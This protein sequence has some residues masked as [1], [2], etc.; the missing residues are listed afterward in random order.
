MLSNILKLVLILCPLFLQAMTLEEKVGQ[1]LI[2]HFNGTEANEDARRLIQ[3]GHVGGIIY[4]R[5]SNGLTSPEQV[6]KLSEGLQA[7]S[8]TPLWICTDQE[9][10]PVSRLQDGFKPFVGNK[11]LVENYSVKEVADVVQEGAKQL[12]AVG[13]NMNL[14]PVVDISTYPSTSYIVRRTFGNNPEVVADYA[15]QA[16]LGY[17]RE[18]I[19]AVIKHFP[20]YGEVSIDPHAALPILSKDLAGLKKW[21]LVPYERLKHNADAVM[22][23]HISVPAVDPKHCAT[24]SEIFLHKILREQIDYRGLVI[25]DSLMMQGL[26]AECPN[27]EE[28]AIQAVNAGC[29][30]LILGGKQLLDNNKGFELTVA[31]NL[32][33]ARALV[34]A[35]KTGRISQE[36]LDDAV[37]RSL[38]F[39]KV[40]LIPRCPKP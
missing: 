3:Q 7:L 31:D 39:K 37:R 18:R 10:G 16:I 35:V 24:L 5:W 12:K 9:G 36:R 1:L 27:I 34:A 11:E 8:R 29:D 23:A 30:L 2:V 26:L 33:I 38:N 32:R 6:R 4:Y 20:G 13:I 22:T 19:L 25:S 28:A 40:Y 17:K 14:A 15:K 21:E